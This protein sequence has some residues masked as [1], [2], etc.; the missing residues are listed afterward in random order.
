MI[1]AGWCILTLLLGMGV[2]Y[3]WRSIETVE[4]VDKAWDRGY[5]RGLDRGT[6]D[7]LTALEQL[8]GRPDSGD[9]R[10]SP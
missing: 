5:E 7:T 6:A 8:V 2:G 3:L 1:P 9:D 10:R 4:H